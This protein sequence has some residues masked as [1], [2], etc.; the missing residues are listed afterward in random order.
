MRCP[1]DSFR[2][3]ELVFCEASRCAWIK[4]PANT[5]SNLGYLAAALYML[6]VLGRRTDRPI[7]RVLAVV[8]IV[9]GLGSAFYHASGIRSAMLADYA[10]MFLGTAALTAL[11]VRRWLGW[12]DP[13]AWAILVA[14]TA[15]L[16]GFIAI[17][18]GSERMV[19]MVAMPCCAI[20][21]RLFFRDRAS[22][23]YRYYGLA[24]LSVI[25]GTVFWALDLARVWCRPDDHLINGH[26][27]WHLATAASLVMYF[28]YYL[29][30]KALRVT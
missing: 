13:A 7:V 30:F 9:T 3:S 26:A 20:E 8:A 11:N 14:T 15:A 18:P 29:Q 12:R 27:L 16:L 24:W 2:Q 23:S 5:W 4:E 25:V 17:F 6:V 10:G 28:R 19:F 21:L 22:I 1:W